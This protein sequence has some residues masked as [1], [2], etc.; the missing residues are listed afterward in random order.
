[1]DTNG[2]FFQTNRDALLEMF[3]LRR[4]G[5]PY[6]YIAKF[7]SKDRSTIFLHCKKHGIKP[8]PGA[9]A[10]WARIHGVCVRT[11]KK[12]VVKKEVKKDKYAAILEEKIC[13]GKTYAQYLKDAG[14]K[15]PVVGDAE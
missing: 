6:Q 10:E 8:N 12:I 15:A 7:Y 2:R 13:Q 1:M 4:R 5:A 14:I 9:E 11:G 3:D